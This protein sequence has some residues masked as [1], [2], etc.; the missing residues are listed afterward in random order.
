MVVVRRY[1][2]RVGSSRW[3]GTLAALNGVVALAIDMSLPAQPALAQTFSVSAETA[4]LNLSLFMIP[5]AVVQVFIGYLADAIGRR[6]EKPRPLRG[7]PK[8]G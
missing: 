8:G 4:A 1:A 6:R 3:I 2:S 5:Y 7:N